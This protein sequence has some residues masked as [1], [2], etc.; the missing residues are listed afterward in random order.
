MKTI[1]I[2]KANL[3]SAKSRV[4]IIN[5]L[6]RI[7]IK[8]YGLYALSLEAGDDIRASHLWTKSNTL[9]Y[10]DIKDGS[11]ILIR[12][13]FGRTFTIFVALVFIICTC[14]FFLFKSRWSFIPLGIIGIYISI[15][16]TILNDKYLIIE[17]ITNSEV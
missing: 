6:N 7:H 4:F 15:Y 9:S 1:Q 10:E 17:Q 5:G 3:F 14:V 2:R 13:R 16:L 11:V 12:P 8:G